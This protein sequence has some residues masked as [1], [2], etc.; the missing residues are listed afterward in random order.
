MH[1]PRCCHIRRLSALVNSTTTSTSRFNPI[2]PDRRWTGSEKFDRFGL[3]VAPATGSLAAPG[4]AGSGAGLVTGKAGVYKSLEYNKVIPCWVADMDFEAPPAVIDALRARIDHGVYGYTQPT[5]D[6]FECIRQRHGF[7][8]SY[9]DIHLLPGLVVGL[10]IA[11][12]AFATIDQAVMTMTPVYP[13]FFTA[14]KNQNRH[15]A[16]IPLLKRPNGEYSLD[17]EAMHKRCKQAPHVSAFFLC[18]PHNPVGRVWSEEELMTIGDFCEQYDL[19]LISDEVHCD[20]ILKGKHTTLLGKGFDHRLVLM[21]SPSKTFNLAGLG[22]AYAIIPNHE[23]HSHFKRAARGICADINVFGYAGLVAAYAHCEPWR[24]ELLDYLRGNVSF[25]SDEL[26]KRAPQLKFNAD[27]HQATYLAWIDATA[28]SEPNMANF[29]LQRANVAT[30]EGKSFYG[31]DKD[32]GAGYFR[33][34]FAC[35]RSTLEQVVD[36]LVRAATDK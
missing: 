28:L 30:N 32:L 6:V 29:L 18:S 20:L 23:L 36:R 1:P 4:K 22:A 7:D 11:A 25:L 10:N 13:P 19:V 27:A 5:V 14:P 34:N 3:V 31:D 26:T 15:S 9:Q 8:G 2:A 12:R 35:S 17:L 16:Q 33:L 24:L 21:H